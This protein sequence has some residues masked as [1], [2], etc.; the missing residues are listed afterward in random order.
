[1]RGTVLYRASSWNHNCH[2]NSHVGLLDSDLT[3]ER[4][5]DIS[6]TFLWPRYKVDP[7]VLIIMDC[8][9]VV[10]ATLV[11]ATRVLS[12]VAC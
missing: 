1:M 6:V 11:W 4:F 3:E 12:S 8:V 10:Y 2:Y 9:A 5:M 7:N